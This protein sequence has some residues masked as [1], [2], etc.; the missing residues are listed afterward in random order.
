MAKYLGWSLMKSIKIV[1]SVYD[2]IEVNNKKIPK[3]YIV[4]SSNKKSLQT[5]IDW[6][7]HNY[8][9]YKGI[10]PTIIETVNSDFNFSIGESAGGSFQGGRLSFWMCIASKEGVP[11]FAV[12]INADILVNVLLQST[13]TNGK[14]SEKVCFARKSG[15]TGVL[16][17]K[18]TEYQEAIADE[19]LKKNANKGKTS[20]WK[21]GYEYNTLTKSSMLL[22]Y[23]KC[24][25]HLNA[26][27]PKQVVTI[28]FNDK[29][30]PLLANTYE[31]ID[32]SVDFSRIIIHNLLY[33]RYNFVDKCPLRQEGKKVI[34][35]KV[36]REELPKQ[37]IAQLNKVYAKKSCVDNE[38]GG[39]V[40]EHDMY[41]ILGSAL[42]LYEDY[43]ETAKKA[44]RNLLV[45]VKNNIPNSVYDLVIKY[46][47][48][49][50]RTH[51]NVELIE[52]VIDILK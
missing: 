28:D 19:K 37:Y 32:G 16:H 40:S 15:Q 48:N 46:N 2:T 36:L 47:G 1:Y 50:K 23:F 25:L 34:D 17:P 12:G 3:A 21:I 49:S 27:Y 5:A 30:R 10:E 26:D 35:E 20:K 14:C 24:P 43:P 41:L 8:G 42:I 39:T 13:F 7:S 33:Y 9:Q 51:S 31:D 4:D 38:Y 44:L 22:G 6:A 11:E 18:M 45:W 29:A 52:Y